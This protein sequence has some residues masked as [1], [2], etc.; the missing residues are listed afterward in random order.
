MIYSFIHLLT[1]SIFTYSMD[2]FLTLYY[3]IIYPFTNKFISS[4]EYSL[5]PESSSNKSWN[6]TSNNSS[7]DQ[8]TNNCI[9]V[10]DDSFS[11][12]FYSFISWTIIFFFI[13]IKLGFS[14]Q[15]IFNSIIVKFRNIFY[16]SVPL[17][18]ITWKLCEWID[19]KKD[20]IEKR[21]Y[22]IYQCISFVLSLIQLFIHFV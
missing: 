5:P 19:A 1:G 4:L 14:N 10:F 8:S 13:K 7:N 21:Y 22:F 9:C 18:W 16:S 6:L 15:P 17:E 20:G 2:L 11:C 3:S 12:I